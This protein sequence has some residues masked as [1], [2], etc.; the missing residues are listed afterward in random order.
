[1]LQVKHGRAMLP[2]GE[3]LVY[4]FHGLDGW[5]QIFELVGIGTQVVVDAAGWDVVVGLAEEVLA[6]GQV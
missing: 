1:M 3:S 5:L 2:T 6:A 4:P